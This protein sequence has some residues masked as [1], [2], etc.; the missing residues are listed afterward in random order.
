M[1]FQQFK[2]Y[3]HALATNP[4]QHGIKNENGKL[5]ILEKAGSSR[6]IGELLT[7]P[8]TKKKTGFRILLSMALGFQSYP[9]THYQ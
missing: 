8:N 1:S 7:S 3:Q 5:V 2:F 6:L 9:E 4:E